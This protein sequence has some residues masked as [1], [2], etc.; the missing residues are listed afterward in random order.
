MVDKIK[1]NSFYEKFWED[2]KYQESYAF[3]VAVQDRLPA[4][5]KVWSNFEKP[6]KVLD[7]GCGNGVLTYLLK[8]SGFGKNI[9]GVDVSEKGITYA[10]KFFSGKDLSFKTMEEFNPSADEKF[11]LIISSHV[12][13]HINDP[14]K[15]L[16]NIK[17]L[18]DWFLLEVPL[19]RALWP[20]FVAI[21]KKT[22][23]ENN[24][25]G[26]VNFWNKMS[27]KSFIESKN[28]LIVKDF[29][30]ASAPF[31]KYNHWIKRLLQRALL[32]VLGVNAYSF[33][34]ATH[35]IVLARKRN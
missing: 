27:F 19:E 11:D 1:Q 34:M 20:N 30:Y 13:E 3:Y 15:S 21:F 18:S 25:L 6:N 12:F 5:Y 8:C 26:H 23:R 33:F 16:E 14:E 28:L 31:S 2:Y 9:L 24:S 4:I 17:H 29:H 35:F 10:S 32:Q 7:F 22:P